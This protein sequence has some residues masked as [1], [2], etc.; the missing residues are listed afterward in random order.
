MYRVGDANLDGVVDGSDFGIWNGSKFT[1]NKNWCNGNFNAD[2]VTDGSDFGLWNANKFTSSDSAVV[3]EPALLS[4]VGVMLIVGA[5]K[6]R[7][8]A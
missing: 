5:A 7:S 6:L 3:P 2:A 8:K 1:T 4:L